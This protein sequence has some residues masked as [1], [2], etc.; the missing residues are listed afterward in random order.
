MR[1]VTRQP[2]GT[3]LGDTHNFGR[4][5]SARGARIQKPRPVFWEWLFLSAKSPLRRVLDDAAV[6]DGLGPNSFGFLPDLAFTSHPSLA[7]G[8]VER[9]SLA[10][11][12][13]LGAHDRTELAR[14]FGRALALFSWFGVTDLHWENLALGRGPRGQIVF[15][16]LDVEMILDDFALPTSTKL[17]PESD[18]DYADTYRHA[19]GARRVLPWLGKPLRGDDLAAIIAAYLATLD[20]LERHRAGI[21]HV[22]AALPE[23]TKT[24]IRVLL[25]ATGDYVRARTEPVWPP[26][27]DAEAE[28]LARGDIPYFFRLY[29]APGIRYYTRRDLTTTGRL[30]LR[31]D[32]PQL[33]PLLDVARGL[34]RAQGR[35]L[36]E[37][38]LFA[39][40]G[41][42][43]H[44]TLRGVFAA[45]D[46]SLSLTARKVT[47]S[48]PGGEVLEAHRKFGALVGSVY[49]PC[50]CG[51]VST[52]LVP[53]VTRCTL[54][55]R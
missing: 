10:P 8:A 22:L 30:P 6:E 52:A 48:L 23:L 47:L 24:P 20:L 36:R 3:V 17:L 51:E 13:R 1:D 45:S 32:V 38:G 28:Q 54:D 12:G 7:G 40:L 37:E 15:T 34:R 19:A 53:A 25:R 2:R 43:D 29:G 16:P 50:R 14:I 42:F 41:A 18:A 9:V 55:R 49:L 46:L 31:G 27:L 21:A 11:L 26:L 44:P 39:I 35:H 33:A 5:V 4:H